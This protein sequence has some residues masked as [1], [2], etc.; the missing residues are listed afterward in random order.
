MNISCN[1]RI[2]FSKDEEQL[3]V[4]LVEK[5]K[6]IIENKKSNATTWKDKEK[7]WQMIEKEFNSNSGQNPRN[8]KQLK[9]KYLNM[10]KKTKQKFSNEKR[11][12]SQTGGGPHIPVDITNIDIAIKDI[13][14]K[15]IT[16]L[17]NNYDCDSQINSK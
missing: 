17:N 4:A 1:K 14:G 7:A 8:S 9:E 15:Q 5:Y 2:N 3:L 13:I 12:N 11:C 6:S 10:K 16:G